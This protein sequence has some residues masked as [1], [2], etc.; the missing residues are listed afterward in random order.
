[1]TCHDE[2]YSANESIRMFSLCG[3]SVCKQLDTGKF[4]L[5]SEKAKVAPVHRKGRNKLLKTI[6]Q[7]L[8]Y[9]YAWKSLNE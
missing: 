2:I 6:P 8:C 5:E 3:E 1:M 7:L 9:Q 4:P